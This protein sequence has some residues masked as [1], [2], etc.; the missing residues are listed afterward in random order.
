[1]TTL[2][3]LI[4]ALL[5]DALIGD[6]DALW[7]RLPHPAALM[8]RAIAGFDRA[9]NRAPWQRGGGIAALALLLAGVTGIG[10]AIGHLPAA[11]FWELGLA[12]ILLAQNSL[13]THVGAVARALEQGIEPGRS[14][15]AAIV[16]RDPAQLD[17]PGII[18]AAIESLAENFS[19]GVVAPAFWFALF[20]LPGI[21]AYKLVN[22]ADS[23]IGYKTERH[24]DFGWAAARLDDLMNWVPARLSALLIAAAHASPHAVRVMRRDARLH[25]SP[26]AGWPEAATAAVTGIAI[27][28]P[29]SYDGRMSDDPFVHPEGR[30]N[31]IPADID[32][33]IR[34]IWRAWGLGLVLLILIRSLL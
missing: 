10:L 18:R 17:A 34:A 13:T 25:R 21:L 30:H 28:G 20:G 4:L 22:T 15:V 7:R 1:M 11:P 16:G 26:N 12:A 19:D 14:A 8:G 3:L 31:L 33:A 6:P 29:R 23:M 32:R 9:W 5:L 2:D 24:H 27:S